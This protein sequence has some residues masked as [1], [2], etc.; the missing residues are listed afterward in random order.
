[1]KHLITAI[2]ISFISILTPLPAHALFDN[3]TP[4]TSE[5]ENTNSP[6]GKA[7]IIIPEDAVVNNSDS[8]SQPRSNISVFYGLGAVLLI[9]IAA[10]VAM[11]FNPRHSGL[12]GNDDAPKEL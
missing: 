2:A 6:L 9:I 12:K 7:R 1:M 10:A 4:T 8:V 5:T 3:P 11:M